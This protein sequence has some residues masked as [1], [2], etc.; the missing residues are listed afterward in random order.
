PRR[1]APEDRPDLTPAH[2]IARAE[3][4]EHRRP[5]AAR[6]RRP[7]H[8][9]GADDR[10]VCDVPRDDGIAER[11]RITLCRRAARRAEGERACRDEPTRPAHE[12][13]LRAMPTS[14]ERLPDA[15]P[16]DVARLSSLA[17]ASATRAL[18]VI[19]VL[20]V[21]AAVA[22]AGAALRAH[23]AAHPAAPNSADERA[24]LTLA[25]DLATTGDY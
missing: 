12:A 1:R 24:Y 5:G 14:T 13:S 23:R 18:R 7:G 10:R 8:P 20:V 9:V 15:T 22:A 19:A 21:L 16:A 11:H 2:E 6:G 4:R 25:R 17:L 3:D